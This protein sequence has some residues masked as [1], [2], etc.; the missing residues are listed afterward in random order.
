MSGDTVTVRVGGEDFK[1][2]VTLAVLR[3]LA[4]AKVCPMYLSGLAAMA[5]RPLVLDFDQSLTV[6]ALGL[7]AAGITGATPESVWK[8]AR[9][10]EGGSKQVQDAALDYLTVFLREMPV[11]E[12]APGPATPEGANPKA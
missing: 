2:P 8:Q 12:A 1:L 3:S 11:T 10:I 7:Q 4:R 5:G 6:V 9:K